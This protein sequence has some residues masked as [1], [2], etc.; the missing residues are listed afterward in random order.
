MFLYNSSEVVGLDSTGL[1]IKKTVFFENTLYSCFLTEN[2]ILLGFD[3][4]TKTTFRIQLEHDFVKNDLSCIFKND[5]F[6]VA[7]SRSFLNN[8]IAT[9]K[10]TVYEIINNNFVIVSEFEDISN[11]VYF[12]DN[13]FANCKIL[14]TASGFSFLNLKLET[15]NFSTFTNGAFPGLN[16]HKGID[17]NYKFNNIFL[18]SS[19]FFLE[20]S[21]IKKTKIQLNTILGRNWFENNKE[22]FFQHSDVLSNFFI[23]EISDSKAVLFYLVTV[24]V[25]KSS[26]DGLFVGNSYSRTSQLI[27]VIEIKTTGELSFLKPTNCFGMVTAKS[28]P[29]DS[30]FSD[31]LFDRKLDNCSVEF[32]NNNV[33]LISPKI[34]FKKTIFTFNSKSKNIPTLNDAYTNIFFDLGRN[35]SFFLDH[36]YPT[37]IKNYITQFKALSPIFSETTPSLLNSKTTFTTTNY[38]LN[39]VFGIYYSKICFK[40]LINYSG[41][42]FI[43]IFGTSINLTSFSKIDT[44]YSTELQKTDLNGSY[45]FSASIFCPS[46]SSITSTGVKNL[47]FSDLIVLCKKLY[48]IYDNFG[49]VVNSYI[50][51]NLYKGFDYSTVN[52]KKYTFNGVDYLAALSPDFKNILLSEFSKIKNENTFR[53]YS[54]F[55]LAINSPL[56]NINDD[57]V[58]FDFTFINNKYF[59]IF[60]KGSELFFAELEDFEKDNDNFVN[61]AYPESL[62]STG[63]S[64][65]KKIAIKFT[66][67]KPYP[68][69]PITATISDISSDFSVKTSETV[70]TIKGDVPGYFDDTDKFNIFFYTS[71]TSSPIL[72]DLETDNLIKPGNK[73]TVYVEHHT[74]KNSKI[75]NACTHTA[76][77]MPLENLA[78]T[79][80]SYSTVT[81]KFINN[82]NNQNSTFSIF[83]FK[84]NK[85]TGDFD[86]IN[87]VLYLFDESYSSITD[88]LVKKTV[89][90]KELNIELIGLL[91]NTEYNLFIVPTSSNCN[92]FVN[93]AGETVFI[94]TIKTYQD[95]ML[96]NSFSSASIKTI[97]SPIISI[98]ET[99][100]SNGFITF[101]L[102]SYIE[103]NNYK[104]HYSYFKKSKIFKN[105]EFKSCHD[106][107]LLEKNIDG[108]SFSQLDAFSP[109]PT[110]KIIQINNV[111]DFEDVFIVFNFVNKHKNSEFLYGKHRGL[112]NELYTSFSYS[113]FNDI[114][115]PSDDPYLSNKYVYYYDNK[116]KRNLAYLD[117][118]EIS[119]ELSFDFAN[120][121]IPTLEFF[122]TVTYNGSNF[123]IDFD[124]RYLT[125]FNFYYLEA[126]ETLHSKATISKKDISSLKLSNLTPGKQYKY[127]IEPVFVNHKDNIEYQKFI[128]YTLNDVSYA[129][130]FSTWELLIFQNTDFV[131]TEYTDTSITLRKPSFETFSTLYPGISF[132]Q[133][134]ALK[135]CILFRI[136]DK[137]HIFLTSYKTF[138][139]ND[140]YTIGFLKQKEEYFIDASVSLIDK[141]VSVEPIS[142][143]SFST[144]LDKFT[145]Y[146]FFFEKFFHDETSKK[147][148][149]VFATDSDST[150]S[151]SANYKN[152]SVLNFVK[153]QS[154]S[155]INCEFTYSDL[156]GLNEEEIM[157]TVLET[158]GTF[159]ALPKKFL[160]LLPTILRTS[161]FV[162]EKRNNSLILSSLV[163]H[164]NSFYEFSVLDEK[165]Y[166][167]NFNED[168]SQK[169]IL[170]NGLAANTSYNLNISSKTSIKQTYD[171][172]VINPILNY[173]IGGFKTTSFES[174]F[175]KLIKKN[176]TTVNFSFDFIGEKTYGKIEFYDFT[177]TKIS[178][179]LFETSVKT[180]YSSTFQK[181]TTLDA[182]ECSYCDIYFYSDVS[183]TA[184]IDYK[185]DVSIDLNQV[186]INY[187]N[188]KQLVNEFG[189]VT[190]SV[191]FKFTLEPAVTDYSIIVSSPDLIFDKQQIIQKIVRPDLKTNKVEAEIVLNKVGVTPGSAINFSFDCGVENMP[192]SLY[193]LTDV[194]VLEKEFFKADIPSQPLIVYEFI[195]LFVK[196][197]TGATNFLGELFYKENKTDSFTNLVIDSK[198]FTSDGDF[199]YSPNPEFVYKN[200]FYKLCLTSKN[201]FGQPLVKNSYS[202]F[203]F[204]FEFKKE[205]IKFPSLFYKKTTCE[206]E[207][208]FYF[209]DFGS[210][211]FKSDYIFISFDSSVVYED[212][213][214][215]WISFNLKNWNFI[216]CP[217]ILS[218]GKNI[219]F[220][221][222]YNEFNNKFTSIQRIEINYEPTSLNYFFPNSIKSTKTYFEKDG[223]DPDNSEFCRI[224]KIP[225]DFTF[226][227]VSYKIKDENGVVVLD[228]TK[229]QFASLPRLKEFYIFTEPLNDGRY[230]I[231]LF[232]YDLNGLERKMIKQIELVLNRKSLPIPKIKHD[233]Q[234]II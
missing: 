63:T 89:N 46:S 211:E 145:D 19:F 17:Q 34:K 5:R 93:N 132:T 11:T 64:T 95:L 227:K 164:N 115:V 168:F 24:D 212:K 22:T 56:F 43:K 150:F 61:F 137:N 158:N 187:K 42:P 90:Q 62:I 138:F 196:N 54:F 163:I 179:E 70:Y 33:T 225:E 205:E 104:L 184:L 221:K 204:S 16:Y 217:N 44:F 214:E 125:G 127:F 26:S 18:N 66:K 52:F 21:S 133:E 67:N 180:S 160:F 143:K 32:E 77:L 68:F 49:T 47:V 216:I 159:T 57:F 99:K 215:K 45:S 161:D 183:R 88:E 69:F 167:L 178:E 87:D 231:E 28:I 118:P 139:D 175:L 86:F 106:D 85:L 119:K 224:V 172:V 162:V 191:S 3:H 123:V 102:S 176:D 208:I 53:R 7:Y 181:D 229:M 210:N 38:T 36:D 129:R 200:G 92:T 219:I 108:K 173:E 20:D 83:I 29:V 135:S 153:T 171:S 154:G 40:N 12:E 152:G 75:N 13:H 94:R 144:Q 147:I 198:T 97:S 124:H 96:L 170:I 126:G 8:G 60:S 23:K 206:S 169:P 207:P 146:E 101:T 182:T 35:F 136:F 151:I 122:Q 197:D 98:T 110:T 2:N 82:S 84:K 141:N 4:T 14:K 116:Q 201:S 103:D 112:G 134:T 10:N 117:S 15:E 177:A 185:N 37:G 192:N 27:S 220:M 72:F 121:S 233:S 222:G 100:R 91:P 188:Y 232:L 73:Y 31:F 74:P 105:G 25:A 9:V 166:Y 155:L 193:E 213:T 58:F 189:A 120:I 234:A 78:I 149:I 209:T 203:E 1:S 76:S 109:V 157:F 165:K 50:N 51:D 71:K 194:V 230:T 65:F 39:N 142:Y 199:N 6:F 48:N 174:S 113:V 223:I 107:F 140:F 228:E 226:T 130:S 81:A 195:N 190:D 41:S 111:N 218:Q 114:F 202:T 30:I 131:I 148:K 55:S 80:F 186:I 79:A 156:Y 128:N 59:I